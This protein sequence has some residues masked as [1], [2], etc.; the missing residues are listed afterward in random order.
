MKTAWKSLKDPFVFGPALCSLIWAGWSVWFKD[1]PQPWWTITGTLSLAAVATNPILAGWGK[2]R[3][4]VAINQLNEKLITAKTSATT[5]QA[6]TN[7]FLLLLETLKGLIC[8]KCGRYLDAVE[9]GHGD[10][11]QTSNY[12][13]INDTLGTSL[14]QAV[15]CFFDFLKNRWRLANED[16]TLAFF[17]PS[18]NGD[19]LIPV[20]VA[21]L[22][23]ARTKDRWIEDWDKRHFKY[24]GKTFASYIWRQARDGGHHKPT[25]LHNVIEAE[26]QGK[27]HP[28]SSKRTGCAAGCPVE[29]Q[30]N[31][32]GEF[33]GVL[34]VTVDR[35]GAL[36]SREGEMEAFLD[37]LSTEILFETRKE[38]YRVTAWESKRS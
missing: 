26:K 3:D 29:D 14:D 31:A 30:R 5:W 16:V 19:E 18:Q 20:A 35:E 27:W 10:P 4:V 1:L 9:Q 32:N 28:L 24:V 11:V 7:Y 37:L 23:L 6:K 13:H 12:L 2:G 33:L 34:V 25:F 21:D 38:Q 8:G 36:E 17:S 15:E 22:S